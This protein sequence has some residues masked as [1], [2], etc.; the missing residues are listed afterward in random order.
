MEHQASMRQRRPMPL[1]MLPPPLLFGVSFGIGALL[2][3][4]VPLPQASLPDGIQIAGLVILACGILL[5][6]SLALTFL[7]RHTTLNPFAD[8]SIFVAKGPYRLSRNPMYVSLII[9]YAGGTLLLGSAWPLLTLIMPVAILDRVVIPFE[10]SQ[11]ADAFG[12]S[13]RTYRAKVRRWF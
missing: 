1:F 8:P 6:V 5:G 9:T 4:F 13:Y 12:E 10:E 2:H 7:I 11:M 3:H